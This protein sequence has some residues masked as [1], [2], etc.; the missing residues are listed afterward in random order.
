MLLSMY[1]SYYWARTAKLRSHLTRITLSILVMSFLSMYFPFHVIFIL[2]FPLLLIFVLSWP[3]LFTW[4]WGRSYGAETVLYIDVYNIY[5]FTMNITTYNEY[6]YRLIAFLLS[7]FVNILGALFGY[8]IGK[9]LKIQF[10]H[11]KLWNPFWGL[12]GSGC[13]ILAVEEMFIGLL[14]TLN[15]LGITF[16]LLG[17][18]ILLLETITVSKIL[19]LP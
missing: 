1:L 6:E 13:I 19:G 9:K 4:H 2:Y 15:P 14:G 16:Y 11:H 12:V 18:G 5:F 3:A 8:L 7:C 10:F 17:F